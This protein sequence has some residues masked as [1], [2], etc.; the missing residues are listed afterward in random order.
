MSEQSI[1][2]SIHCPEDLT[3]L[4]YDELHRLAFEIRSKIIKTVSK[5]GGHLASNL[6]VVELSLSLHRIFNSPDD[7]IVWDVG[8]QCYTHK[9]ITGRTARFHTI[10]R[11]GGISGFPKRSE[12]THDV[13]ETGHASTSISA[14]LGILAADSI[15]NIKGHTIAVIGDGALTGGL[16][17]E[18]LS[19]AGQLGLPLIVVLNDNKMSIGPNVG[20]LSKYLSQLTMKKKYQTFRKTVDRTVKK[21]PGVGSFLFDLIVRIKRGIK[22]VFYPENFFVD[23]GFEYVGPIDGH[24]IQSLE[25]V[26]HDVSK[27]ERPVVVHVSTKKG[28]GYSKAEHDPGSFHGVA[29][30]QEEVPIQNTRTFTEAFGTA[31]CS[32]AEQNSRMVAVCAAMEKGT[33]LASFHAAYPNRFFDVGIAEEHALTFSAGLAVRGL[34]PVAAIY[35][36]FIQRSVDQV[37]HDVAL[38]NIPLII[39]LDRS[40]FVPDDGE[41]HQG[42]FDIALFRSVP[43]LSLLAPASA[44]ELHSMLSWA[45]QQQGPVVLR[46]PKALCPPETAAFK[47]LIVKGRGTLIRSK[48]PASLCIAFTGGLYEAAANAA[49]LLEQKNVHTDLYNLRFLKPID[50]DYLESLMHSYD[51]FVCL[52]EG[53]KNGGFGEYLYSFAARKHLGTSI[54]HHAASDQ[55]YS[56]ADRSELLSIAGFDANSIVTLIEEAMGQRSYVPDLKAVV[57]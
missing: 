30:L 40:G 17:Y 26:F 41:T 24:S 55:F 46:Y 10:R 22:S 2:D 28:K 48:S 49:A 47:Q 3:A 51:Y 16:A 57:S 11:L 9:L 27:L 15:Q 4:N 7:K 12:S 18:A 25:H 42:L 53:M 8:H 14:A 19:H 32:L 56:Q 29:P 45:L 31:L 21:I 52:E 6:G 44:I 54:I 43:N 23:L 39:A 20:A 34:R 1:L 50:E 5:N 37:I 33:G 13:F 36:T 35:S 38:Q